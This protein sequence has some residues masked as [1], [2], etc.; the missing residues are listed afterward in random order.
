[1]KK[2]MDIFKTMNSK[3]KMILKVVLLFFII[4]IIAVIVIGILKNRKLTYTGIEDKL[5]IAARNYY[6]DNEELLPKSEGGSV[7]V[8]SITLIENKYIKELTKYNKN[9]D[10]CSASVRVVNNNGNY[11]NLPSLK[12]SDYS[13]TT[14]Y[15]QIIKNEPIVEEGSGLY[16]LNDEYVYRGEYPNNYLKFA[17]KTWRILSINND[18]EIRLL[19]V[20]SFQETPWDN[21][22]NVNAK[23]S[24]GI[25]KYEISRIKDK[26]N[27]IYESTFTDR[28]KSLISSKQLCIGSRNKRE[29]NNTGSAECSKLTEEYYPLGMIQVNE[30]VRVSLDSNCKLQTDSSCTNYNYI[31]K[32][33]SYFWT[34]TPSNEND[35]EVFY[36]NGAI[37]TGIAS[38]FYPIRLTLNL[39]DGI[40]YETGDGTVD[41]PYIVS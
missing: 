24:S 21:R 23:Y 35:Y 41:N 3:Q 10:S 27:T 2:L 25:T 9:A 29:T 40:R 28:M 7:T 14:L 26:L 17:D 37:T 31:S 22:Y 15:D 20:D 36:V 8:D 39:T 34:I 13:T 11:L 18:K 5:I 1:M 30:F 16:L 19:Q 32:L 4:C 6:I 33:D 12:C 38:D